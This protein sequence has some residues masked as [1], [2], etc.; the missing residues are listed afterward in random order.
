MS[1]VSRPIGLHHKT[2]Q[3][4]QDETLAAIQPYE[5]YADAEAEKA[6][7][8]GTYAAFALGLAGH[9]HFALLRHY[10][11]LVDDEHQSVQD[12]YTTMFLEQHGLTPDTLATAIACLRVC[13]DA[14]KL[15]AK[16][17]LDD[18]ATLDLLAAALA[19]LPEH[20]RAPVRERLFGS[21]K[22]LAAL[23]RKAGGP[24]KA[25]LLR[26]LDG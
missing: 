26:L 20:D 12:R 19:G 18:A 4:I 6:C 24:H 14:F 21:D 13:T 23:A 9:R 10:M 17:A 5:W 7:L 8:S 1:D 22:K 2:A 16:F 3:A 11:D 15:P 25:R